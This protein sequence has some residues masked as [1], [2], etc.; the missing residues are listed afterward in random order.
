[1]FRIERAKKR[2]LPQILAIENLSFSNPW[3]KNLF[4]ESLRNFFVAKKNKKVVGYIGVQKLIDEAHILHMATH[5]DFRRQG[6]AYKMMKKAMLTRAQK[7]FLEVRKSNHPAQSLYKDFGFK[8]MAIRNK[9]Y[10]DNDEDALVM[11][12]E[13][14]QRKTKK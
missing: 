6:V 8:I 10:S 12:Y 3:S 4:T 1:M 14:P 7:F 13:R 11:I 5:P 9:Y 2:D